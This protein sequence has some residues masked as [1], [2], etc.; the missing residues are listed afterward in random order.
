MNAEQADPPADLL[1]FAT[2]ERVLMRGVSAPRP[3][4]RDV[5][6]GYAAELATHDAATVWGLPDFVF[7]PAEPGTGPGSRELGDGLLIVRELGIVLQVKSRECPSGDPSREAKWLAKKAAQ[8]L[9]QGSG[10]VR[11]LRMAPQ[12]LINRR[13][14]T[15]E[16][17]ARQMRWLTVVVL[18]H[19][20]PPSGTSPP[21]DPMSVIMVRRDWQFLFDQLKS[22]H[23]VADYCRRVAGEAIQLGD[24]PTRYYELADADAQAPPGRLDAKLIGAGRQVSKPM[25]PLAPAASEDLEAHLL[26]RHIFEAIALSPPR[27]FEEAERLRVLAELDRLPVSHRADIGRFLLD[28]MDEVEATP[29]GYTVWK[30][31]SMRGP[32]GGAHLAYA[33]SSAPH[34]EMIQDLF[35]LWVRVRHD[36]VLVARGDIEQLTT[37]GVLLTPRGGFD[38]WDT[39]LAATSGDPG[40]TH[41]E[42]AVAKDLWATGGRA[43]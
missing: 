42:R 5:A 19:E 17:D 3:L 25:L 41:E 31:R 33:A 20:D 4:R 10:T 11:R 27:Q 18:D 16:V 30:M 15:I 36:E 22:T 24:E 7:S 9:R 21:A 14:R 8:A 29:D 2:P 6:H 37:V 39:T 40:L 1:V 43:S 12:K 32:A 23:A 13:G 34:S 26:V 28:A 38:H 35:G